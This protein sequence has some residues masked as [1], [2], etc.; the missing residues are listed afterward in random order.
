MNNLFDIAHGNALSLISIEEDK[1]FLIA[2]KKPNREGSM[3]GID[4]KLTAAEKR[5]AERKKKK[6]Q[7]SRETINIISNCASFLVPVL[8]SFST[9]SDISDVEKNISTE[10]YET[11]MS[12]VGIA[13]ASNSD[14]SMN[15]SY[16][17]LQEPCSFVAMRGRTLIVNRRLAATMD[18]CKVN[19]RDAVHLLSACVESLSL[20]SMDYVTN[21]SSIRRVR[22]QY[23]EDTAINIQAE[24]ECRFCCCPLGYEAS[25][26]CD[27]NTETRSFACSGKEISNAVFNAL[28]KWCLVDKVQAF[29]FDTTSFN[30]G[31]FNGAYTLLKMKLG[32][33]ILFLAWRHHIFELVLQAAMSSVELY[34][35]SGVEEKALCRICGFIVVNYIKPWFTANKTT[36]APWNDILLLNNLNKYKEKDA[37]VAGACLQKFVNHLWYLADEPVLFSLFDDNVPLEEKQRM[38]EKLRELINSKEIEDVE[39]EDLT[40]KRYLLPYNELNDFLEKDLPCS[41]ITKGL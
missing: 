25:P 31:R 34:S 10:Q 22:Q 4:L 7:K 12:D 27:W 30:T 14:L 20:N 36:E 16:N 37:I 18:K 6:K 41:L 8:R 29:V 11:H 33:N 21:R 13:S 5:K 17:I 32:R 40:P 9:D 26:K 23:R 3:I 35:L 28:E 24:F 19:D 15:V 1:K 2:Q 38:S 39:D